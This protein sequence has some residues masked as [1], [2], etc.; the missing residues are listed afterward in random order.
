MSETHI[1]D[2]VKGWGYTVRDGNDCAAALSRMLCVV[3]YGG[4]S[5][6]VL[7][8][9]LSSCYTVL[10]WDIYPCPRV[11]PSVY[12][13]GFPRTGTG[14]D[15]LPIHPSFGSGPRPV[16]YSDPKLDSFL[17]CQVQRV[18]R[19]RSSTTNPIASVP[20]ARGRRKPSL[21]EQEHEGGRWTPRLV[22]RSSN[23]KTRK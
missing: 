10:D 12:P 21:G 23:L 16:S 17:R 2:K 22:S 15:S 4:V 18:A 13:V 20:H 7:T 1:L 19:I 14:L 3:I 6:Y 9:A 5:S 11:P 8:Y